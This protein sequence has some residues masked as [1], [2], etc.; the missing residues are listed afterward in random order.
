M[1]RLRADQLHAPRLLGWKQLVRD[2]AGPCRI[3][4]HVAVDGRHRSDVVLGDRFGVSADESLTAALE[5]LFAVRAGAR[6]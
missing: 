2:H 4:P 1:L 5:R 3:E 6:R